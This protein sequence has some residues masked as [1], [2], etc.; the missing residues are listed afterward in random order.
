MEEQ[1]RNEA[2]RK[3]E[4]KSNIK[5]LLNKE[6]EKVLKEQNE[7]LQKLEDDMRKKDMETLRLQK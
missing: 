1:I 6:A 4:Q 2:R 3:R 5:M 7:K